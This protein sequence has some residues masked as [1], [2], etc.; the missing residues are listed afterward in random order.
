MIKVKNRMS[1]GF[2]KL[3]ISSTVQEVA[4]LLAEKKIGSIFLTN[5][6]DIAGVVT[7]TDLVRKIMGKN[8]D[9][10]TEKVESIM[11]PNIITVDLEKSL[12][13]AGDLMDKHHIRHLGVTEGDVIVGV[14]S[15]RDLI[16][17]VYTDGEG[18]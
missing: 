11:S 18:W 8:L 14:L 5:G 7:E 4:H 2:Q 1:T 9:P 6:D 10:A 12:T 16:H 13:D 17:P 3:P 15:V